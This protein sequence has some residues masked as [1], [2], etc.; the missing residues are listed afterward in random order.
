MLRLASPGAFG[1]AAIQFEL[2]M[3][4][5][6]FLS[7]EGVRNAILRAWPTKKSQDGHQAIMITNVA[8][9]PL[10][11]G[12]P[13]A[14][15]TCGFYSFIAALEAKSQPF[16]TLSICIY[17]LAAVTELTSEPMHIRT[18]GEVLTGIRVKAEGTGVIFKTLVTCAIL[19]G[20]SLR[21]TG[22]GDLALLAFA[23]GQLSYSMV[24][25]LTYYAHFRSL[26]LW[27]RRP[28]DG[29]MA[30]LLDL[31]QY[32]LLF[33]RSIV[34]L[35]STMTAQ[36]LFKHLLTEGDKFIL[37]WLSPLQDQGGYALAVNYGG[38]MAILVRGKA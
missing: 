1:I 4:T 10:F 38:F 25:L 14:A 36:S 24:V 26:L 3:S 5:I 6:L 20:D 27:P 34:S 2:M 18:M 33:D 29:K 35:S 19:W 12:I 11:I 17:A 23:F 8:T 30:N 22:A 13:L 31:K 16:F 28:L 9:L 21:K 7:R 15:A 37:S 32:Q